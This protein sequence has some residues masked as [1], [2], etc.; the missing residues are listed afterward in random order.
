MVLGHFSQGLLGSRLLGRQLCSLDFVRNFPIQAHSRRSSSSLNSFW[1]SLQVAKGERKKVDTTT[2]LDE[3]RNS[4]RVERKIGEH[5]KQPHEDLQALDESSSMPVEA[6]AAGESAE[7]HALQA[8]PAELDAVALDGRLPLRIG[9]PTKVEEGGKDKDLILRSRNTTGQVLWPA[10]QED[11]DILS[12]STL[13][14]PA[15]REVEGSVIIRLV[16]LSDPVT[17]PV[18]RVIRNRQ[19]GIRGNEKW[20]LLAYGAVSGAFLFSLG[21]WQLDRMEWKKQLIEKRRTRLDMPR[22][23]VEKGPFPWFDC[24]EDWEYRV[25]DM[26]G[27]FDHHCEMLVGPRPSSNPEEKQRPGFVVI[28]P[29]RLADGSTILVNRGHVPLDDI[30][31]SKR[32]EVPGWVRVRG[33]LDTGEH[34]T[35]GGK[36]ARIKNRPDRNQYTYIVPVDLAE[37]AGARNHEEC[38]QALLTALDVLY[39]DDVKAGVRRVLP[40]ILKHKNDY[41]VFWADEHTHFNYAMQW[42]AL[43]TLF[44]SMTIYKFI[45]VWNWRY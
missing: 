6:I 25:V 40:Y 27:V 33:V 45:E 12:E 1:E 9:V 10:T 11:I 20:Q 26:R 44:M 2:A 17:S 14:Y 24:V 30:D 18:A 38:Q 7:P 19:F 4:R 16:R 3:H 8:S 22:L 5:L 15:P 13:I 35:L 43:G 37:N 29:L 23:K 34:P 28:T 42:F 39:E 36:Y 32:A 31:P 21:F 41:M